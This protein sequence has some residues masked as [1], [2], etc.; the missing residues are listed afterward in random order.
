MA[1]P[2]LEETMQMISGCVLPQME[3]L[4]IDP[5]PL[6]HFIP[7]QVSER[8][9]TIYVQALSAREHTDHVHLVSDTRKMLR[10][11]LRDYQM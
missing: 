8:T 6:V 4:L 7:R 9:G 5:L 10:I 11:F 2:I 3:G 1:G